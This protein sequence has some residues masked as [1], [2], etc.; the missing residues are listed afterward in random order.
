MMGLDLSAP[1]EVDGHVVTEAKYGSQQQLF[2]GKGGLQLGEFDRGVVKAGG[3]C[4]DPV[5]GESSSARN[6][7]L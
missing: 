1:P 3:R 4:C 7:G 6:G 2:V 5:E